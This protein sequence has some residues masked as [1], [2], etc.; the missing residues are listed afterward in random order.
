MH[1][2][3]DYSSHKF[4]KIGAKAQKKQDLEAHLT[5]LDDSRLQQPVAARIEPKH[6]R[7]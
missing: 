6:P 3:S 4:M 1:T 2:K 7:P 5:Y